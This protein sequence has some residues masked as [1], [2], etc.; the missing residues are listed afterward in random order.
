MTTS[1]AEKAANEGDKLKHSLLLEVLLRCKEWDSLTYAE[2][3]A[4]AGRYLAA[5]QDKDNHYI[6]NLSNLVAGLKHK[7]AEETAGSRYFYLLQDWWSDNDRTGTYPGSLLQAARFLMANKIKA[8]FR[9]TEADKDTCDRLV[10]AVNDYGIQ[11]EQE[12]FQNKIEWLTKND[13]L[14]LLIDPLSF[15]ED[16]FK[17]SEKKVNKGGMDLPTLAKLLDPC[18]EKKSAVVLFWSGFGNKGGHV[19][20]GIAYGWLKCIC[21]QK[22]ASMCCHHDAR[23][24]NI[25]VIGIGEGKKITDQ[26]LQLD[27]SGSWLSKTILAG[28]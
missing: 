11:P 20:K 8:E 17:A 15:A 24:H 18:W 21:E 26:L 22:K 16:F 4:G 1:M 25:F 6:N 2:T 9:A 10:K 19:K 3:H 14:V 12:K 5:D 13:K 23:L 7:P 27:W 28:L